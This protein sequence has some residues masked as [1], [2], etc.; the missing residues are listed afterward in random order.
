MRFYEQYSG[1]DDISDLDPIQK[2]S[3]VNYWIDANGNGKLMFAA[4]L[5]QYYDPNGEYWYIPQEEADTVAAMDILNEND[6]GKPLKTS[7]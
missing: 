5:L 7:G 3:D 1:P 4:N 6:E 2:Y